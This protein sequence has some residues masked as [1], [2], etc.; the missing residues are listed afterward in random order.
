MWGDIMDYWEQGY[1]IEEI[2]E[3]V[4]CDESDVYSCLEAAEEI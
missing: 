3:L 2:A 1:R 4:G